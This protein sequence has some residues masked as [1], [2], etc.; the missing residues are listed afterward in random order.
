MLDKKEVV[1]AQV[2]GDGNI[3]I[4]NSDNTTIT[5]DTKNIVEL[6]KQISNLQEQLNTFNPDILQMMQQTVKDAGT[7]SLPEIDANIPWINVK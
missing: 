3:V 5:I 2:T 6:R 7:A 1:S 4:Q